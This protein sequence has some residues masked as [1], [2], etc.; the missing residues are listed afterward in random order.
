[1]CAEETDDVEITSITGDDFRIKRVTELEML[2]EVFD[3]KASTETSID[4]RLLKGDGRR[5]LYAKAFKGVGSVASKLKAWSRGPATS[6]IYGCGNWHLSK[7][8]LEKVKRWEFG[9][10]R[11][12]LRLRRKPGEGQMEY[13]RRTI[14][15]IVNW[16][17]RCKCKML[18]HRVLQSMFMNAWREANHEYPDG[19]LHLRDTRECRT[20]KWW[21]KVKYESVWT[22]GLHDMMHWTKGHHAECEDVLVMVFG[23]DWRLVRNGCNTREEWL[24]HLP[25]FIQTV[26]KQ[27]ELPS[28][29]DTAPSPQDAPEPSSTKKMR[30][31]NRRLA[32]CLT[33]HADDAACSSKP[34]SRDSLLPDEGPSR[35][36]FVVDCKPLQRIVCGHSLLLAP[37]LKPL[38]TRIV[39]HIATILDIGWL[40][41]DGWRDPVDWRRRERNKVADYL[42]NYTMDARELVGIICMAISRSAARRMQS[43]DPFL[44]GHAAG[45]LFCQCMD[46]RSWDVCRRRVDVPHC[47]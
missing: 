31:A 16:F 39:K 44:W 37:E 27:W 29:Q 15:R 21:S 45:C 19:Q 18:H 13:N 10:L 33:K 28:T 34:G 8:S 41:P 40:P 47:S 20:R 17:H 36:L 35:F 14:T 30:K 23:D 43:C 32:D 25:R 42:V 3:A 26:C 4:H 5:H 24:Q 9:R 12:L 7:H 6:A 38:F 46:N 2:G 22:R 11:S 1:V